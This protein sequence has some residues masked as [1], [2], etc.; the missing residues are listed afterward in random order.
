MF[1]DA[2]KL[3]EAVIHALKKVKL[4]LAS[5]KERVVIVA[6]C[7]IGSATIWIEALPRFN[8][9]KT[10]VILEFDLIV[11]RPKEKK[12]RVLVDATVIHNA[13][14]NG[15]NPLIEAAVSQF[16]WLNQHCPEFDEALAGPALAEIAD[17]PSKPTK[18]L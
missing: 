15:V 18:T 9:S 2:I 12:Q 16:G 7:E 4:G 13:L 1:P 8:S 10:A 17:G 14:A 3:R 11:E 6:E 5:D